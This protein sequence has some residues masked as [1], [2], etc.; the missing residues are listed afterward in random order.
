MHLHM[1]DKVD[2]PS[3]DVFVSAANAVREQQGETRS[4]SPG[5]KHV[6]IAAA[7]SSKKNS[8]GMQPFQTPGGHFPVTYVA[9]RLPRAQDINTVICSVPAA[10]MYVWTARRSVARTAM[11]AWPRA[12]VIAD[13]ACVF[14]V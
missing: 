9:H 5:A 11:A 4:S 3:V 12:V 8:S 7:C 1:L 14:P 2:P 13:V 6:V 10:S